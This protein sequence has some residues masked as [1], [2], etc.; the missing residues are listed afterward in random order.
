VRVFHSEGDDRVP[1]SQAR[2]FYSQLPALAQPRELHIVPG[3]DHY[4]SMV[5]QGLPAGVEWLTTLDRMF[6]GNP[7]P[8]VAPWSGAPMDL[9]PLPSGSPPAFPPHLPMLP[10]HPAP[11]APPELPQVPA[12][13]Y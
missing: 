11:F 12:P 9:L 6:G 1:V 7:T 4:N 3:G 10:P 2:D 5:Q 13:G 8:P